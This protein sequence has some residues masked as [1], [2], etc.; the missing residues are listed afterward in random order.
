[1][2]FSWVYIDEEAV[3]YREAFS[4]DLDHAHEVAPKLVG[5]RWHKYRGQ[6]IKDG[7]PFV[8]ASTRPICQHVSNSR[9]VAWCDV[10]VFPA[11][12]T[13]ITCPVSAVVALLCQVACVP[14][15]IPPCF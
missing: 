1:M 13:A 15:S 10:V 14:C 12:A 4:D 6:Q 8:L 3:S 7:G 5:L 9:G 11:M 2:R